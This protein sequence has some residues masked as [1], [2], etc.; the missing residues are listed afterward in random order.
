MRAAT[1]AVG[2]EVADGQITD[3]NS[4]WIS[5][6]LVASGIEVIE[7]RVVPD[8]REMITQALE[9]LSL[10]VDLLFVTGGLGPTS[11]DF[12]R[13]LIAEVFKSPLE[14]NAESWAKIEKR[15][16]DRGAIAKPIQRQQC[17]FPRGSQIL[18]NPAGTANAFSI[19]VVVNRRSVYV[20]TLPGPPAEI[21]AVWDLHLAEKIEA[22]TP[23]GEREDLHVWQ[24]LGMGEGD[25]AEKVEDAIRGSGLRVGYRAHLPYIEVKL[26]VKRSEAARLK[27]VL[28]K[29]EA[30]LA[31]TTVV[32]GKD[33]LADSLI[34]A[35]E[36]GEMISVLDRSSGG[37][38]QARL[39]ERLA[40]FQKVP[41]QT[42]TQIRDQAP[43]GSLQVTTDLLGARG[44]P[45]D[46]TAT[47]VSNTGTSISLEQVRPIAGSSDGAYWNLQVRRHGVDQTLAIM[48]TPLYNFTTERG[49]KYAVEKA[50]HLLR[51]IFG[52]KT[53]DHTE[54][55]S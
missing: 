55:S 45:Q 24:S 31:P 34:E 21:A 1:L 8:D 30:V 36:R 52:T 14:F 38:L 37:Y 43:R 41:G 25:I 27:P 13:D 47:A 6:K 44:L 51:G 3:R 35:A 11:D 26:W 20:V 18:E 29:I 12:T 46:S 15:F 54:I 50:F 7:H 4:S 16:A 39:H 49:Q 2:T 5:A 10:K 22:L 33:D 32:R 53:A 23:A 17:F 28:D 9:E 40:A 48:P 19:P 42:R